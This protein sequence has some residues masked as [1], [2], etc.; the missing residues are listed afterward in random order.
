MLST[1][2]SPASLLVK[3]PHKHPSDHQRTLAVSSNRE[4]QINLNS[5]V[6][7][8]QILSVFQLLTATKLKCCRKYAQ[9]RYYWEIVQRVDSLCWMYEMRQKSCNSLTVP[10]AVAQEKPCLGCS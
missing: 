6:S 2:N 8:G 4:E 10:E 9:Q 5:V 3:S 1:E 7:L